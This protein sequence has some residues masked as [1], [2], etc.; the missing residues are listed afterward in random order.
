[1]FGQTSFTAVDCNQGLSAPTASTLCGAGFFVGGGGVGVD[2][3]GNVYI[4][5]TVNNR[6]LQ[7]NQPLTGSRRPPTTSFTANGV[8]GQPNFASSSANLG[9]SSPTASSLDEPIDVKLDVSGNLYIV[10]LENSRVLEFNTP[11]ASSI[12]PAANSVIGQQNF[13][14]NSCQTSATC[15]SESSGVAIGTSLDG[16]TVVPGSVFVADLNNNRVLQYTSPLS[17]EGNTAA[18]VLGQAVFDLGFPNLVDG[19]GLN[20]P[21]NVTIDPYSTPNHIYVSDGNLQSRV[22][23]WYDAKTF[24]GGQPADLVFGQP[25]FYHIAAN[26]DP[27]GVGPADTLATPLG[28]TVDSSSN[29]Y[30]IDSGNNRVLEYDNPFSGFVP[31]SGPTLTPPEYSARLGR[32]HHRRSSVR[33]LRQL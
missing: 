5:D 8:F 23:A 2:A 17:T 33:H 26:N 15:M 25:D 30:I 3:N 32:R 20:L 22:L 21:H 28:M 29:L 12:D 18:A 11:A 31:G 27:N 14:D 1:M 7:F 16:E 24:E 10:D 6:V 9:G 4:A 19:K 13:A